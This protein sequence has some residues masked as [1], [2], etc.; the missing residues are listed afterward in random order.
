MPQPQ[1]VERVPVEPEV[2]LRSL[3]IEALTLNLDASLNVHTRSHFFTWTQGLLQ[4]LIHHEA[5]ICVLRCHDPA[6]WRVDSF[7]TRV[8]DSTVFAAPLLR[9]IAL[10]PRL[11]DAWKAAH[12][13]PIVLPARRD[14][15][16]GSGA[17]AGEL[18]R[19][20][21]TRLAVHGCHDIDGEPNCLFLFACQGEGPGSRE[22]CLLRL[23]VPFL[24]EAWVRSQ[25]SGSRHDDLPAPQGHAVIT[26]REQEILKWI[27]LGKSNSEIGQI[28]G[29]SALTVKNHVQK[30]LHKLNVVNRAQA[31]GRAIEAHLIQI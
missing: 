27:Y 3:D 23:I 31:V 15:V 16:L 30:V 5:L 21:A 24:R 10:V 7:S 1:S 28:L 2:S 26:V 4:G 11:V 19:I 13:L 9:D 18:E 6:T 29:I 22:L 14:G 25:M 12:H 20:A 17:L 8:A